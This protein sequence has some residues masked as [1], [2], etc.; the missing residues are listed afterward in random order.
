MNL[1][2]IKLFCT[3]IDGVWTDGSMYY[4]ENGDE[5]KKFHTYDSAGVL[6]LKKVGIET[7][8]ITQENTKIVKNRSDKLN[9]INL[10]QGVNNKVEICEK[11][12]AKNNI[13]FNE[14]AYIGDDIN[15]IALIKK[16]GLSACPSSAP[17]YIQNIVDWNIPVKGG[18]GAFRYF[19]EKFLKEIGKLNNILKEF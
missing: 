5:M 12:C 14:V 19:V 16:V 18:D 10:Y 2:K 11:L 9:I 15:D 7:A 17:K 4:S 3:D 8:I 1:N 13:N 6:F